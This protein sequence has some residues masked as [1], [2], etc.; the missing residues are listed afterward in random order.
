[1]KDEVMLPPTPDRWKLIEEGFRIRWHF[2]NCIGALDGKHI[3]IKSPAK[4][5]SLFFNYKGHFSTN[6][7]ALVDANYHFVFV[8]IGE[9]GSNS[10]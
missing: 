4:S 5:G 2:P 10:D 1:M 9:Y 6:L 8:D 7:M 3:M